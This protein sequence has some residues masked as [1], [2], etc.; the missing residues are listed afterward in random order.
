MGR[1]KEYMKKVVINSKEYVAKEFTF[2]LICDLEE[3]GYDMDSMGNKPMSVLRAY[4]S[5]C[6]GMNMEEAG[7]EL[8]KHIIGGGNF[9]ELSEAM[10]EQLEK[11]DFF[12]NLTQ[13]EE[14]KTTEN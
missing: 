4:F 8:E 11:S 12:R 1:K 7:K 13:T 3:M 5:L 6:A 10:Q 2:N 9:G 14:K